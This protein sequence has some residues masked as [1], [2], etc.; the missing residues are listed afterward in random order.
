MINIDKNRQEPGEVAGARSISK[1]ALA[2]P[3]GE[4]FITDDELPGVSPWKITIFN[5]KT[6]GKL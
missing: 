1:S 6:M 4:D 2:M 5:R 3:W